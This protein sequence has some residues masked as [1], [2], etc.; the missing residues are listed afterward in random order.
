M[1]GWTD[2]QT[3]GHFGDLAQL[4]LRTFGSNI[5]HFLGQ[6]WVRFS[7]PWGRHSGGAHFEKG[8]L[9]PSRN[10]GFGVTRVKDAALRG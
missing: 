6:F 9:T 7:G 5:Q 1:T 8:D 4:K 2:G 3:D 10:Y